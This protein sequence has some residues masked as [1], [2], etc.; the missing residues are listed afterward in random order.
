[1]TYFAG[2]RKAPNAR[3][4]YAD[5]VHETLPSV[6]CTSR[7]AP[8]EREPFLGRQ[9]HKTFQERFKAMDTIADHLRW[10]NNDFVV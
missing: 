7:K 5:N 1:M 2:D 9:C 3:N 6:E 8:S 4:K 10:G